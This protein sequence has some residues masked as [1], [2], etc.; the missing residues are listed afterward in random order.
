MEAIAIL[1]RSLMPVEV[2]LLSVLFNRED[3][4]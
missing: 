1:K 3:L 4:G 2:L